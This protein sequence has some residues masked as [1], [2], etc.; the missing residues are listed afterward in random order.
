[1]V[2][3][4][5]IGKQFTLDLGSTPVD[6][7]VLDVTEHVVIVQYLNSTPGRVEEFSISD[8]EYLSSPKGVIYIPYTTAQKYLSG[9][10]YLSE[11]DVQVENA[12]AMTS[13]QT[14]I[15]I[16]ARRARWAD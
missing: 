8:F 13:V 11:I 2:K 15:T 1:M 10:K 5:I 7:Y 3:L 16:R 12:N 14:E 4:N 6:V 9:N